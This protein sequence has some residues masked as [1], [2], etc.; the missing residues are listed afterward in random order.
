M[1]R[2]L[3]CAHDEGIA[4]R[5]MSPYLTS[6]CEYFAREIT[7]DGFCEPVGREL[8]TCFLFLSIYT[9]TVGVALTHIVISLGGMDLATSPR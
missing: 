9:E 1:A 8:D 7:S 2:G 5:T 4:R 6:E 3:D